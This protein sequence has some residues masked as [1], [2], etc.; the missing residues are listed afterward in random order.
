[1]IGMERSWVAQDMALKQCTG[2]YLIFLPRLLPVTRITDQY[3][4]VEAVFIYISA[5]SQISRNNHVKAG[6]GFLPLTGLDQANNCLT[7]I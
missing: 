3:Q 2:V 1:M 5:Y 7:S 6:S 4:S